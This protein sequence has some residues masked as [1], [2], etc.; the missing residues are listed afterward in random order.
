M[1]KP[2]ASDEPYRVDASPAFH[3]LKI[4]RSQQRCRQPGKRKAGIYH[5]SNPNQRTAFGMAYADFQVKNARIRGFLLGICP[6]HDKNSGAGA[7]L[8]PAPTIAGR[9]EGQPPGLLLQ[10][11]N[12]PAFRRRRP[13]GVGRP[14]PSSPPQ[15]RCTRCGS[16][17]GAPGRPAP[18]APGAG[19]G[20]RRTRRP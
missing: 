1:P 17:C 11:R 13:P 4:Q 10:P 12:K 14:G 8:K 16:R 20:I 7:G 9:L 18:D 5:G 19:T 15:W 2:R 6:C 3:R